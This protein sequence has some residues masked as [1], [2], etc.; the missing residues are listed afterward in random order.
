[1]SGV[2]DSEC[3]R[4]RPSRG[5]LLMTGVWAGSKQRNNAIGRIG[6]ED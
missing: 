2:G 5:T 4:V 6:G 3:P 1:M